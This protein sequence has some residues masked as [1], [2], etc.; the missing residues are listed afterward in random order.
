MK[1]VWKVREPTGEEQVVF[2]QWKKF[3]YDYLI[4][5]FSALVKGEDGFANSYP[6]LKDHFVNGGKFDFTRLDNDGDPILTTLMNLFRYDNLGLGI[7]WEQKNIGKRDPSIIGKTI[8][9]TPTTFRE[10]LLSKFGPNTAA[11][12]PQKPR[13][14]VW[15]AS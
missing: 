10:Y 15:Q 13:T 12:L 8:I 1:F 2:N 5:A 14:G 9:F 11:R 7:K 6:E 3:A 4:M